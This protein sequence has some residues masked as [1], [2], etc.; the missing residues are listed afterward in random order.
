MNDQGG[1]QTS[2]KKGVS[3]RPTTSATSGGDPDLLF[4]LLLHSRSNSMT[5]QNKNTGTV[6]TAGVLVAGLVAFRQVSNLLK[7]R[8][9]KKKKETD[10]FSF[11]FQ[12][13]LSNLDLEKLKKK[14]AG[15]PEGLPEDDAGPRRVPGADRG[16][17]AGLVDVGAQG[18]DGGGGGGR[19]GTSEKV[20]S[21]FFSLPTPP[22]PFIFF[23]YP[24]RTW[25]FL[26]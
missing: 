18:E 25:F 14:I 23:T 16:Y 1:E 10:I 2:K 20:M 19:G 13:S 4:S 17:D 3:R 15:Q 9:E 5:K 12:R 26:Q 11:F 7:V 22:R 8:R 24:C 6:A 21:F